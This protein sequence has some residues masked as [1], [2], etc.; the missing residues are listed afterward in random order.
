M[1]TLKTICALLLI[2]YNLFSQGLSPERVKKIKD[3][4]VKVTIEGGNSVGT[5]FVIDRVGT[6]LTC[7]HVVNPV[8]I[9]SNTNQIIGYRKIIVEF[10]NGQKIEYGIP[11][12][13]LDK[14]AKS[15]IT[16]DICGLIPT[17][18]LKSFVD[19]LKIGKFSNLND[20]DEVVTCGYPFAIPQQFLSRG[21]VSTKFQDSSSYNNNGHIEKSLVNYALIDITMNHGNSGGAIIKLGND[22]S[23]DEVVGIADFIITPVGKD[24][25]DLLNDLKRSNNSGGY[26]LINGINPNASMEKITGILTNISSGIS[27][28][29]SIEYLQNLIDSTK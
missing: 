24:I 25:T 6:I 14:A 20:G 26:A 29:V 21:I 11:A 7:W 15:L 1:K 22:V 27:G 16:F 19:Y 28:C 18:P 4:T 5:G 3:C 23:T 2:S 10:N 8:L 12:V 17:V 9:L 13:F